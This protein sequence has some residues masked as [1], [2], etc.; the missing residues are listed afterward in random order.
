MK[1]LLLTV[2]LCLGVCGIP[3]AKDVTLTVNNQPGVGA[4]ILSDE[5][6]VEASEIGK[7]T[8]LYGAGDSIYL[9]VI[10][11]GITNGSP[12][13]VYLGGGSSFPSSPVVVAGPAIVRLEIMPSGTPT[14]YMF[15]NVR[16]EP[17]SFPPGQTII[18]PE[19]TVGTVHVESSTNLVSWQD[20][21]SQ[22]F[23]DTSANRFFRLRAERSLP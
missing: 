20:E 13:Q 3:Q 19:G 6:A 5:V 9:N 10:K 2:L 14:K 15:A 17:E 21:W 8:S 18:L 23:S 11:N 4:V 12:A 7:V 22:T 16:I 1:P